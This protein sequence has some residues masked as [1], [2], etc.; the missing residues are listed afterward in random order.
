MLFILSINN[1]DIDDNGLYQSKYYGKLNYY[2]LIYLNHFVGD[3]ITLNII[4]N[5]KKMKINFKLKPFFDDSFLISVSN[6]DSPPEFIIIGGLVFQELTKEYL[7]IWG[8]DWSKKADKRLMYYY[9]NFSKYP[10]TSHRRFVILN[11]VLPASVNKGY[12][13]MRYLILNKVNN[14]EVKD[15]AHSKSTIDLLNE[16]NIIMDFIGENRIVLDTKA[17]KASIDEI[18]RKYNIH[19]PYYLNN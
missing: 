10:N 18:M 14:I 4:R 13:N 19:I 2:G 15:L 16:E 12:F 17:A 3:S 1:I 5:R 11:F 9:D 8:K 6:Y 7:K